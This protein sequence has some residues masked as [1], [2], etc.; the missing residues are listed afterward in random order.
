METLSKAWSL[1]I[2]FDPELI[3][4]VA[5]SLRVSLQAMVIAALMSAPLGA[6]LAIWQFPGRKFLTIASSA[7][8]ALPPVVVGLASICYFPVQ[9]H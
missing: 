9:G 1:I 5:L 4:I 6:A 2:S 7:L 3:A 8:M